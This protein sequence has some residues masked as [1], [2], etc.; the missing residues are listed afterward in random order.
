MTTLISH[1]HPQLLAFKFSS[2]SLS[3]GQGV[4]RALKPVVPPIHHDKFTNDWPRLIGG[5][6]WIKT[7]GITSR[8]VSWEALHPSLSTQW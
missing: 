4:D 6:L 7:S 1:S 3:V 2:D 8:K 5:S